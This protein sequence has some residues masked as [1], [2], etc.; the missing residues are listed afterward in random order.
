MSDSVLDKITEQIIDDP[1]SGQSLLL[2]ALLA[3]LNV[4]KTGHMYMLAKLKEFTPENRQLAYGVMEL[5]A[6]NE[7][8]ND[9]WHQAYA[10]ME[11]AIRG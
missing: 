8:G 2:F 9:A 4:E 11:H 5:M 10:K 3:T 7:I 1:R 6:K